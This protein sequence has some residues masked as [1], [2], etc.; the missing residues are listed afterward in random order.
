[1]GLS[2][3]GREEKKQMEASEQ[4]RSQRPFAVE[5]VQSEK[6]VDATI[7]KSYI[8]LDAYEFEK[9]FKRKPKSKDPRCTQVSMPDVDG[10]PRQS[11]EEVGVVCK[12]LRSPQYGAHD[13]GAAHAQAP[14]RKQHGLQDQG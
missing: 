11:L 6:H 2:Q 12:A 14:S 1:M 8:L 9:C 4:D 3:E 13:Q 10:R 5:Q 7:K